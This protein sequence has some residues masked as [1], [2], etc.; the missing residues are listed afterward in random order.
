MKRTMFS[1]T[2]P[3]TFAMRSHRRICVA[4]CGLSATAAVATAV[5]EP[6][7]AASVGAV[8]LAA[9]GFSW[10][11]LWR[12]HVTIDVDGVSFRNPLSTK[13]FGWASIGS[14]TTQFQLGVVVDGKRHYA[15]AVP[16]AGFASAAQELVDRGQAMRGIRPEFTAA[17]NSP[18]DRNNNALQGFR[19]ECDRAAAVITQ[20]LTDLEEAGELT[21]DGTSRTVSVTAVAVFAISVALLVSATLM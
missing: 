11:A 12:P 19:S 15:W 20:C 3:M 13:K 21:G 14:V 10:L 5:Y 16:A 9:G 8:A 7:Q 18:Q 4:L 1:F 2:L 17:K 6:A